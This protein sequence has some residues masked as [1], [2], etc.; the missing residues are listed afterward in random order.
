MKAGRGR[1]VSHLQTPAAGTWEQQQSSCAV[2]QKVL[3]LLLTPGRLQRKARSESCLLPAPSLPR[4]CQRTALACS[5][6]ADR[7]SA[8]KAR[9]S[10]WCCRLRSASS[11]ARCPPTAV[12]RCCSS[13]RGRGQRPTRWEDQS[14]ASHHA[15]CR[16]TMVLPLLLHRP[17][18][19]APLVLPTPLPA[20]DESPARCA[21]SGRSAA[22]PAAGGSRARARAH[23]NLQRP[24]AECT[25]PPA[26]TRAHTAPWPPT[27]SASAALRS[28]KSSRSFCSSWQVALVSSTSCGVAWAGEQRGQ[29]QG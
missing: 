6:S 25:A 29:L 26:C 18:P 23:C 15:E 27:L 24:H 13:I 19:L 10:C 4:S 3:Q 21:P 7:W 2:G 17:S 8:S 5:R 14:A 16:I 9:R 11:A 28:I 20:G 22:R 12:S 1:R